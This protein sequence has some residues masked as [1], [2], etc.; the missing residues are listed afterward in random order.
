MTAALVVVS[1]CSGAT[2]AKNNDT[3][4]G[5]TKEGMK[6]VVV[7]V[8]MS[9]R[10]LE[11]AV[12]KFE[13]QNK[14]IKI[15]IKEYMAL[16]PAPAEG[17]GR[18][19]TQADIEKYVQSVTTEALSGKGSDIILTSNLPVDQFIKKGVFVDLNQ[20]MEKDSSFDKKHYY[21]NILDNMQQGNG[22]YS[23]PLE[24]MLG[25]TFSANENLLKQA[26]VTFDDS[27]WT[28]DQFE[29]ISKQIQQ[30]LGKDYSAGLYY[31]PSQLFGDLM[32]DNYSELVKDGKPHFDS[33][34]FKGILRQVKDLKESGTLLDMS[35]ESNGGMATIA[36]G[37]NKPENQ[38]FMPYSPISLPRGAFMDLKKPSP[39]KYVTKPTVNG[40]SAGVVAQI[41]SAYAI[42]SKSVVQPEA[43]EFLKFLLSDEMQQSSE[44]MGYPVNK[45]AAAKVLE[46]ER[47]KFV[48]EN[49]G[50]ATAE[51]LNAQV[52]MI[53]G[54]LEKAKVAPSGDIRLVILIMKD[55]DSFMEG[56]KSLE[57]VSKL[58]QNRASTY[59]N[60]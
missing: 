43:W 39:P 54:M 48:K 28:W 50:A 35:N 2:G 23:M 22:F 29:K 18:S 14:N 19:I 44:I 55:F 58:I 45:Q 16:P 5:D 49:E 31:H 13:Q 34:L 21:T 47:E 9:S 52:K 51:K 36:G 15:E 4:G 38:V 42:N 8:D 33:E 56:Q 30:K 41:T 20:W 3:K 11:Q 59:L 12:E 37:S 24:F 60:E 27:T 32:M 40:N 25:G 10:L 6:K 1:A 26:G 53:Q 57:E 46:N 17:V 7:A